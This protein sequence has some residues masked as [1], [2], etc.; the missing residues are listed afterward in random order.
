[1]GWLLSL[2]ALCVAVAHAES[3]QE[4]VNRLK[5]TGG[6]VEVEDRAV[7]LNGPLFLTSGITLRGSGP[8]SRLVLADRTM[9]PLLSQTSLAQGPTDVRVEHLILDGNSA[10]Q[11]WSTNHWG[12]RFKAGH[13]SAVDN[14]GVYLNGASRVLF[15]NVTFQNFRNE[16][17]MAV[18][19]RD[20]RITGCRFTNLCQ[21]GS[22]AN[23]FSQG[24]VYFRN[25]TGGVLAGN[26]FS[27]CFEGG[28]VLGL[29]SHGNRIEGNESWDSPS[30]EGILIGASASNTVVQNRVVRASRGGAGKGAGISVSLP[31]GLDKSKFP[32][33]GNRVL[34]NSI[35]ETGGPGIVVMRADGTTVWGNRVTRGNAN[36][37]AGQGGIK[38]YQADGCLVG[39][40]TIL[41]TVSGDPLVL[42]D[43]RETKRLGN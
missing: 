9:A 27:N 10:G 13:L 24:A 33:T 12:I 19:C 11:T 4:R 22:P 37:N 41:A 3:L 14:V 23:D 40:N 17:F 42:Q 5:G 6:V 21:D 43:C 32:S 28:I 15:S 25:T 16:G 34:S 31:V 8:R 30:G 35:E 1:M 18:G 36:R 2:L 7:V 39:S 38:L 26:V 20:V 29:G